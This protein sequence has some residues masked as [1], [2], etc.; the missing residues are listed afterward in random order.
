MQ[1]NS[2]KSVGI[3]DSGDL[4]KLVAFHCQKLGLGLAGFINDFEEK[5]STVVGDLKIIG[6]VDDV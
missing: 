2:S 3:I 6:K 4:G 5:D 1:I